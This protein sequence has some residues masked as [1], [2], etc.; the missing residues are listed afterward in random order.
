MTQVLIRKFRSEDRAGLRAISFQTAFLG[1][2]DQFIDCAQVLEDCLTGYFTDYEPQSSW[3][4]VL[5]DRVVGYLNGGKDVRVVY[6]VFGRRLGPK[7]VVKALCCG[8][9]LTPRFWQLAG[10]SLVSFL[11]G[12]FA[13]PD[14]SRDYPA[15]LH[16][17]LL[18]EARGQGVGSQMLEEYFRYLREQKVR[19]VLVSA[20]TEEG[21]RFFERAG[22]VVLFVSKRTFLR[23]RLG[24]DVPLYILGKKL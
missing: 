3:V 7:I 21:K 5:E 18:K 16:V 8:M 15:V 4:A 20:M 1:C 24:R 6:R 13:I 9:L 12:E 10:H 23:H 14:F 11:K 2:A 22:F 17:N 19:G